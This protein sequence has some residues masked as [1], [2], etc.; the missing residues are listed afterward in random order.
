MQ[1]DLNQT[2]VLIR[3]AFLLGRDQDDNGLRVSMIDTIGSL[4]Q[5]TTD[6]CRWLLS[7]SLDTIA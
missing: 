4:V 5:E 3:H 7:A 1:R 6:R 2:P